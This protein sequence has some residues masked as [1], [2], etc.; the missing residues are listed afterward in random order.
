M[1]GIHNHRVS[2]EWPL[3]EPIKKAIEY[4]FEDDDGMTHRRFNNDEALAVLLLSGVVFLNSHHWEEGWPK[5]AREATSINVDT[6]DV[7]AW[8]SAD[9]ETIGYKDIEEIYRYWLKDSNWGTAVWA[10]ILKKELPQRPVGERIREA[11]I[12]DLDVLT[13]EHELRPNHYD[14]ISGVMADR[15]R[16]AYIAWCE[17]TGQKTLPYDA[18]WWNGWREYVRANPGWYSREWH[19]A[20]DKAIAEWKEANGYL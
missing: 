4:S 14:G 12:W 15:K 1:T 7:F 3:N 5:E 18:G 10:I 6:S 2:L 13:T 8:G 19:E 17:S 20:E 11:G 9:A 16:A